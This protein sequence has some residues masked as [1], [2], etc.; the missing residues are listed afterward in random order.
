MPPLA[1]ACNQPYW[2]GALVMVGRLGGLVATQAAFSIWASC[3]DPLVMM[4]KRR[5]LGVFLNI[6]EA[7][8]V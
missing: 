8:I 4:K 5:V 3:C 1:I 6:G 7:A 2:T